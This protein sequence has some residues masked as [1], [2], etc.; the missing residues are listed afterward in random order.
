MYPGLSC[1]ALQKYQ[2]GNIIAQQYRFYSRGFVLILAT[3][4][5]TMVIIEDAD[6]FIT[7]S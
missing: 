6:H 3:R 2:M 5:L 7:S 4:R 1:P